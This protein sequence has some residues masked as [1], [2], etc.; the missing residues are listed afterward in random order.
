M[1]LV[2]GGAEAADERVEAAPRLAQRALACGGG[3]G[4]RAGGG[5][6]AAA[7]RRARRLV[8][9][10]LAEAVEV[11]EELEDVAPLQR[12]SSSGGRC[13]ARYCVKVCQ[14]RRFCDSYRLG[15]SSAGEQ[16]S[17]EPSAAADD[18]DMAGSGHLRYAVTLERRD[19][20]RL[21]GLAFNRAN[22]GGSSALD[23]L[24]YE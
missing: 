12:R 15:R 10:R 8:D 7:V 23:E 18:D 20:M 1:T 22:Q 21:V 6:R 19:R 13:A 24:V 14:S 17:S 5:R 4:D 3:G 2:V 16:P 9:A 11:A